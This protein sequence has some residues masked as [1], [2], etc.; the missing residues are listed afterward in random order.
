VPIANIF[1]FGSLL[2]LH[3]ACGYLNPVEESGHGAIPEAQFDSAGSLAKPL[4][5]VAG[6]NADGGKRPV[7]IMVVAVVCAL[8]P[9]C[10]AVHYTAGGNGDKE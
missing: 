5:L 1:E 9:F 4:V 6:C 7:L 2:L 3:F 8:I 10:L